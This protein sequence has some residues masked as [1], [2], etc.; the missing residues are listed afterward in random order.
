MAAREQKIGI[1][2]RHAVEFSKYGRALTLTLA[3]EYQ[4]DFPTLPE[5]LLTVNF[6]RA[7]HRALLCGPSRACSPTR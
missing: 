7:G 5:P 6:L 2:Y 4:G 1:D 3:G